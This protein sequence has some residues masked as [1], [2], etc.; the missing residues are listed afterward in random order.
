ML[1]AVKH[2]AW[3]NQGWETEG[4]T[5]VV[6]ARA[7]GGDVFLVGAFLIDAWC[8]G[9]KDA[10]SDEMSRGELDG[11]LDEQL[12][13]AGRES[14]DPACARKLIEGAAAYA[15]SLGF[16]PHRDFRKARKALSGIDDAACARDF[17]FGHEGKPCFVP[18]PDDDEL[19]IK[20]VLAVLTAKFGEDGF[21]FEDLSDDGVDWEAMDALFRFVESEQS[22]DHTLSGFFVHGFVAAAIMVSADGDCW[23]WWPKLFGGVEPAL[24][25]DDEFSSQEILDGFVELWFD[26]E[27]GFAEADDFSPALPALDE[28]DHPVAAADFCRGFLQ[29]IDAEPR[30]IEFVP[31]SP[32]AAAPLAVLRRFTNVAGDAGTAKMAVGRR[33]AAPVI[34]EALRAFYAATLPLRPAAGDAEAD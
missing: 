7:Q 33:D 17:T 22:P 18:G 14:L 13:A 1:A 8:L 26:T 29:V 28:D 21:T 15:Q 4:I 6:V 11:M 12:A 24:P 2:E 5:W 27:S 30:A 9:V 20:R 34:G 32:E 31:S 10:Y 23:D 3:I 16:L 19:R 25:D